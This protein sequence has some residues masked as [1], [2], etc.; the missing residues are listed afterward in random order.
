MG[1]CKGPLVGLVHLSCTM[2]AKHLD[3]DCS[4]VGDASW[5]NTMVCGVVR[6]CVT[7][8]GGYMTDVCGHPSG[9][10]I[11]IDMKGFGCVPVLKMAKTIPREVMMAVNLLTDAMLRPEGSKPPACFEC[12]TVLL[13]ASLVLTFVPKNQHHQMLLA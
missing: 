4:G 10:Y 7:P 8:R 5:H 12:L 2:I 6:L 13:R 3:E 1:T 11:K 9:L